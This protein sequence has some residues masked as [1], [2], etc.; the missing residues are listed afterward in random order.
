MWRSPIRLV[1]GSQQALPNVMA[2]V[3]RLTERDA[4]T[5][6]ERERS[7]QLLGNLVAQTAI[8]RHAELD[9]LHPVTHAAQRP[10]SARICRIADVATWHNYALLRI[11]LT[12]TI[13]GSALVL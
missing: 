2:S 6:A 13:T 12:E 4:P 9:V 5:S 8:S 11:Y 7:A 1:G 10:I 3:L